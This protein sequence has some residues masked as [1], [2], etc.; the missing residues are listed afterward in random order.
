MAG[1]VFLP[2]PARYGLH[3][4]L[5][6]ATRTPSAMN[7]SRPERD[8]IF[9]NQSIALPPPGARHPMNPWWAHDTT[10]GSWVG[11]E[12]GVGARTSAGAMS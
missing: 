6:D 12:G 11:P 7:A 3:G 2:I 8:L 5:R 9:A 4:T 1:F 10:K